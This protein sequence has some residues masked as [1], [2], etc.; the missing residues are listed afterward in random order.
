MCIMHAL[1]RMEYPENYNLLVDDPYFNAGRWIPKTPSS[2]LLGTLSGKT[3]HHL[4]CFKMEHT[5]SLSDGIYVFLSHP[6]DILFKKISKK[7]HKT[8]H[9]SNNRLSSSCFYHRRPRKRTRKIN[10]TLPVPIFNHFNGID[11]NNS[12]TFLRS[13]PK[14]NGRLV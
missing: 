5:F 3:I 4:R 10:I 1:I 2:S 9:E 7:A 6:I 12:K 11:I 8:C 13:C 14:H